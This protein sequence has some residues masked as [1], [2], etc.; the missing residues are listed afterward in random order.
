MGHG[1]ETH[2]QVV[3]NLNKMTSIGQDIHVVNLTAP[4]KPIT[5]AGKKNDCRPWVELVFLLEHPFTA[6]DLSW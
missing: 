3:E 5:S 2:I 1:I 6:T 4:S